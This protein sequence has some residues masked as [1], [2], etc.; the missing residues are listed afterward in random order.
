MKKGTSSTPLIMGVLGLIS[1]LPNSIISMFTSALLLDLGGSNNS[2]DED[3]NMIYFYLKVVLWCALIGFTVSL[4]A[5]R[6]YFISG[7]IMILM[8]IIILICI[9]TGNMFLVFPASFFVIGGV[10]ALTQKKISKTS[11]S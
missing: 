8:G 4:L 2:A 9:V 11:K 6:L 10:I 3:M 1:A 7:P 5:K